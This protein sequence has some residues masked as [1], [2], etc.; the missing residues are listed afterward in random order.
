MC[1]SEVS[2]YN[3]T[4]SILLSNQSNAHRNVPLHNNAMPPGDDIFESTVCLLFPSYFSNFTVLILIATSLI[5]QLSHICKIF[6][7]CLISGKHNKL[8]KIFTYIRI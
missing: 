1:S 5:A 4:E 8:L 6:L 7:M 3:L 2:S